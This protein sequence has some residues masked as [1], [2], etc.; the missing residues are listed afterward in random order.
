MELFFLLWRNS[1]S[2][3]RPP[4]CRGF[5]ITLRHTTLGRTPLDEWPARRRELYLTTHNTYKTNI[6]APGELRTHN[7]SKRAAEDPC[8]RPCG[9]GDRHG[10]FDC[11]KYVVNQSLILITSSTTNLDLQ[12]M[13]LRPAGNAKLTVNP[14]WEAV[15]Q[16]QIHLHLFYVPE[17]KT[18]EQNHCLQNV[19]LSRLFTVPIVR[20][21]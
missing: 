13:E 8:L 10:A 20:C 5:M 7:P 18:K 4:R 11:L 16:A 2:G 12:R 19:V 9:Q 14:T 1:P 6:H 21:L 3:P 15:Y 17:P